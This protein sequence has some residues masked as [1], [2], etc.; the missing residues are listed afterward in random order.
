MQTKQRVQ[1]LLATVG[2][3]PIKK[4]G[5]NF[6]ID[7][8]LIKYLLDYADISKDDIVFEVGCGTGSMTESL[9]QRAGALVVVE[10]DKLMY[11]ITSS[12]VANKPNVTIIN[13]DA[14]KNKNTINLDAAE[15]IQDAREKFSGKIKLVANLPYS[16]AA[17]LMANLIVGPTIVDSMYVTIQK[18]VAQRMAAEKG[19]KF[20]GILSILMQAT[21]EVKFLKKLP[22]N[23]FWPAPKV[24]SAMVE[25][26]RSPEKIAM[27]KDMQ[28]LK[29][30]IALLMGH[31]RK[32]INACSKFA[33]ESFSHIKDW[34]GIF[35]DAGVD[36]SMRG[37]DIEAS[38]YV[39]IAN[40]CFEPVE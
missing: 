16:I 25:F 37:E 4:L 9:A 29:E 35:K 5:Q 36:S 19:E 34:K 14:L 40:L 22:P 10:Y 17:S 21:G 23:V 12:I 26:V 8:N 15:A 24:D 7:L 31:R 30:V 18:E 13:A 20:Y 38:V 11:K 32:T 3:S 6:L 39:K 28:T 33:P 2:A 27:I 1:Q